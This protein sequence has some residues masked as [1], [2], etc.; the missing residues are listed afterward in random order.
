M[1]SE[2]VPGDDTP[3]TFA[4]WVRKW[5]IG[6]GMNDR[7]LAV[8]KTLEEVARSGMSVGVTDLITTVA[9]TERA[10]ELDESLRGDATQQI[11]AMDEGLYSGFDGSVGPG[12]IP[13]LDR[14]AADLVALGWDRRLLQV[15]EKYGG[16]RFYIADSSSEM[17][18]RISQAE[19]ESEQICESCGAPGGARRDTSGWIRTRCDDCERDEQ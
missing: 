6:P 1:N 15:K 16:L 8:R 10:L 13:L 14:L 12:W 18:A 11:T 4:N 19:Q 7:N 2:S 3:R 9:G 5:R 17:E